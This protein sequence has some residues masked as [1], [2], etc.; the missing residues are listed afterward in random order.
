VN[1]LGKREEAVPLSPDTSSV[2]SPS[3]YVQGRKKGKKKG[4]ERRKSQRGEG[5]KE[6]KGT[7]FGENMRRVI[8]KKGKQ[9]S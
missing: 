5:K 6:R 3:A 8:R 9:V 4:E 2:S 7:V 1:S